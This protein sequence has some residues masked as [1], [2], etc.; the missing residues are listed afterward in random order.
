MRAVVCFLHFGVGW[1]A[2]GTADIIRL[3]EEN[4]VSCVDNH[5]D[6]KCENQTGTHYFY[7]RTTGNC[8]IGV[9]SDCWGSSNFFV[10]ESQCR[11]WCK[12]APRPP[13]SLEKDTGVGRAHVE[14][15]FFDVDEGNCATFIFGNIGGNGNNFDSYKTC[16]ETCPARNIYRTETSDE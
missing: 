14:A 3:V 15:W 12:D 2:I 5:N 10:K 4:W 11:Q 1:I 13:C 8:S 9:G 6:L 7:N 16:N